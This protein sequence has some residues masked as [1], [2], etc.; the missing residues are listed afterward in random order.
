MR[1]VFGVG[2]DAPGHRSQLLWTSNTS[3]RACRLGDYPDI[4]FDNAEGNAM[5]V[6]FYRGGSFMTED[7]GP[8]A[9]V[10]EP[11]SSATAAL[12]WDAMATAGAPTPGTALIAPHAGAVRARL[13]MGSSK[14]GHSTG[15]GPDT[16]RFPGERD[17]EVPGPDVTDRSPVLDIVDGGAVAITGWTA[18]D[19]DGS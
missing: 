12:G 10:L 15:S 5:N 2:D 19:A 8:A 17:P 13:P 1:T 4:A 18:D 16:V 14:A 7:A 9:V 3:G 6:L 11:G